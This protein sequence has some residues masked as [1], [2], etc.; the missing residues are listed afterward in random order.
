MAQQI[1]QN[2]GF[3]DADGY[4]ASCSDLGWVEVP[5][6]LGLTLIVNPDAEQSGVYNLLTLD[7]TAPTGQAMLTV[8]SRDALLSDLTD[9]YGPAAAVT[10]GDSIR[11]A[12]L[13]AEAER[14][15]G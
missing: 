4:C 1:R 6:E 11:G 9:T 15:R 10:V 7:D 5:N 3:V 13:R 8:L 2:I 14:A 12:V